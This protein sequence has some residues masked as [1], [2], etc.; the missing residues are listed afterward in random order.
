MTW[1]RWTLT[2]ISTALG[3]L[4]LL[5]TGCG[6]QPTGDVLGRSLDF[7]LPTLDGGRLG[8]A[9]HDGVVVVEFWAT[10]CGPCH[11]QAAT[12]EELAPE[13]TKRGATVLSVNVGEDIELEREHIA[14]NPTRWAVLLDRD[15]KVSRDLGVAALPT[16]VVVDAEGKV[17]A[18]EVGLR[19]GRAILALVDDAV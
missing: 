18:V 7:E 4:G 15:E 17:S 19:G 8:P 3:L 9:D 11:M 1:H 12:L 2:R 10:W 16:L 13:L 14:A 5:L 6:G